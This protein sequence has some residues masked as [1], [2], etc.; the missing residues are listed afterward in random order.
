MGG[1][2]VSCSKLLVASKRGLARR[3]ELDMQALRY[4]AGPKK[5]KISDFVDGGGRET[6]KA[7]QS[8]VMAF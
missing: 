1:L 4:P 7:L 5:D 3:P 2:R 6:S 8:A